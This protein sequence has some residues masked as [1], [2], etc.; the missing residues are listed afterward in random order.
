[1]SFTSH[2]RRYWIACRLIFD[3]VSHWIL[4]IPVIFAAILLAWT[5]ENN[6]VGLHETLGIVIL[7][8]LAMMLWRRT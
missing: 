5:G 6:I 4:L 2:S 3:Q 8:I 1:M 7:A